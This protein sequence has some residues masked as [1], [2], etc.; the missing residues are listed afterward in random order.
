MEH[1]D[2]NG[3]WTALVMMDGKNES[4]LQGNGMIEKDGNLNWTEG[5]KYTAKNE[6][7]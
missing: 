6:G 5:K 1:T 4:V 7:R 3:N 2:L